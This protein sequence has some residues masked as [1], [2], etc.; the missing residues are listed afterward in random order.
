LAQVE[1]V[2]LLHFLKAATE[3]TQYF[4]ALPQQAVAV[5]VQETLVAVHLVL[6]AAQVVVV[7][8]VNS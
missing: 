3:A 8:L 6:L 1:Q 4:L 5:V 2:Q 7:Q